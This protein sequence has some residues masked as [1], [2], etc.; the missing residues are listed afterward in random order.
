MIAL[1]EPGSQELIQPIALEVMACS[2]TSTGKVLRSFHNALHGE[3]TTESYG[4]NYRQVASRMMI[5]VL[6]KAYACEAWGIQMVWA[7]QDTLLGYLQATTQIQLEEIMIANLETQGRDT[8]ILFLVYALELNPVNDQFELVLRRSFG[9]SKEG[10][11][12]F[13]V[14][15]QIP[16]RQQ[17]IA[18]LKHRAETS[19]TVFI[20]GESLPMNL[21]LEVAEPNE[22]DVS[23]QEE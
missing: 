21:A 22:R 5:Q 11:A 16:Q 8:P 1:I 7:I 23:G 2:T 4:I 6:A 17:M 10:I 20:L 15:G 13:L 19:P 18:H 3:A 14:P 12:K 9:A